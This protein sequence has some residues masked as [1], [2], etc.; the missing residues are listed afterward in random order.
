LQTENRDRLKIKEIIDY[1]YEPYVIKDLGKFDKSFVM[2]EFE[3]FKKYCG[4]V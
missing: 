2:K 1:G 3:N 4:M